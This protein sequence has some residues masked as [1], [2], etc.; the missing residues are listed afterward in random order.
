VS[1]KLRDYQQVAADMAVAH[2]RKTNEPG[3]IEVSTGG[4]KSLIIAELCRYPVQAGKKCLVLSHNADILVANAEKYRATGEQCSVFAAKLGKKHSAHPVIFGSRDSVARNIKKFTEPVALLIIDEAHMVGEDEDSSYQKIIAHFLALNPGLRILGLTA[5]PSRMFAKLVNDHTTFKHIV[6]R[7]T[8]KELVERGWLVP[9]VYGVAHAEGYDTSALSIKK[10]GQFDSEAVAATFEHKERLTKDI[11]DDVR[12][13]M[14]EQNRKVCMIFAATIEHAKEIMGYLPGGSRLITGDTP[15]G[16]RL[17]IINL[18]RQCKIRYLVNVA[19][20]TTGTDIP[21]VD[22]IAL[23]RKTESLAL[24]Q[25]IIGRG[26]RLSP[27]TGKTDC[28]LL[29]HAGNI[30]QFGEID[31]DMVRGL[32]EAK[33][34]DDAGDEPFYIDCPDCSTPNPHTAVRCVGQT[35]KGRCDYYFVFK[36]CDCGT[37]NAPSARYCRSCKAELV[38]VEKKLTRKPAIGAGVAVYVDVIG[39]RLRPHTKGN[40]RTLRVDYEVMYG[41]RAME[42]MEFLNPEPQSWG[43]ANR[44]ASFCEVTGAIGTSIDRI[45]ESA[46]VLTMPSRL[47]V[48][49]DKGSKYFSVV[50]RSRE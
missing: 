1:Y 12:R 29:D 14:R 34:K 24:L 5:T 8:Y 2:M 15:Q 16:E 13:V 11:V 4:G 40:N 19:V 47:L 23:L 45:V 17:Q 10:N 46:P 7:I 50:S 41:D 30:D 31:D 48:K 18:A 6:Y 43:S 44:F 39:M 38:D 21:S 37:I 22:C 28:L 32:V 3:I 42:V 25:Q 35:Y 26:L 49:R 27:D 20:L 36:T 9:I 33:N